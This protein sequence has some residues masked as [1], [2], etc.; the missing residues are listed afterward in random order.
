MRSIF[1]LIE[2]ISPSRYPVFIT[3]ETGVGKELI[4]RA[5]HKASGLAGNFVPLNVAAIDPQILDD[6]L[7]GHKKG[8]FTGAG[9]TREGLIA[10]AQGGTLFLDE[11]G[12]IPADSQIKLLRLLQ[13]NEYYRL[14]SDVLHKSDA[15]IV[16]A[17]NKDFDKL[18]EEGKFREDLYHRLACHKVD[19]PPLR[20][21][22]EDI[23]PLA[24]HYAN[25]AANKAGKPPVRFSSEVN[26]LL[27]R[28]DFPGNIRELIFMVNN[29]VISN[30]TGILTCDDFP[31]LG[32]SETGVMVKSKEFASGQFSLHALF[33]KFPTMEEVEKLMVRE[34][35]KITGGKQGATA[36]LLGV[37]RQTIMKRMKDL[38]HSV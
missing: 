29:A 8:A 6:T 15:R 28:Q 19:I 36:E 17:S 25:V 30:T 4:A 22:R 20:E 18:L 2:T 38:D 7:F 5:V 26:F 3:G 9:E 34:T 31:N 10:K 14:G 12:D 21:R 37:C 24:R 27:T 33:P 23:L 35:M 16:V 1:K 11:I 32:M 13:E